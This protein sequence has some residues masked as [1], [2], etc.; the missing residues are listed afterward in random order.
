MLEEFKVSYCTISKV[1]AVFLLQHET[2]ENIKEA[3]EKIRDLNP[4]VKPK[5]AMVDFS[6][7]E[8]AALEETFDGI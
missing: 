7:E 2:K 4:H 1:A 8:I 5:Y 6:N 3:L